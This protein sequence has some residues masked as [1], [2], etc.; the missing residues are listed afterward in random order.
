MMDTKLYYEQVVRDIYEAIGRGTS[1]QTLA[2][3][4]NS[5]LQGKTSEHQ[6]DVYWEFNDGELTYKTVI[7]ARETATLD[8]LFALLRIIR[9]IPGQTVGV[10]VTQPVYKKDIKDMADSAGIILYELFAPAAQ[11]IVEPVIE[12]VRINV[13]KEWV[14]HEKEKAGIGDEQVQVMKQPKYAFIYDGQ[15]HCVDSVQ[16]IF[17][18]YS[19]QRRGMPAG[20]K[21]AIA[22]TFH[23]PAFLQTNHALVPF[24]KLTSIEFDLE[25]VKVNELPGEEMVEYI[26]SKVFRY[27]GR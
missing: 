22:H 4:H 23:S 16:G 12:H 21:Q 6:T 2:V 25:F 18:S 1:V 5:L 9:D 20:E 24:V 11:D 10:L 7:Q 3:R 8:E 27:F 15:G 19:K 14:K 17:D 13:D 26:L